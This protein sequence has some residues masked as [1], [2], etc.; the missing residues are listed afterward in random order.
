MPLND[1]KYISKPVTLYI[2]AELEIP[3]EFIVNNVSISVVNEIK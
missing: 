2:L 1:A 3:I